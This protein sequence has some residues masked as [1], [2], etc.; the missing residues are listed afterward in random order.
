[1]EDESKPPHK[2]HLVPPRIEEAAE[3]AREALNVAHRELVRDLIRIFRMEGREDEF[4]QQVDAALRYF[5][6][7]RDHAISQWF[8]KWS[9]EEAGRVEPKGD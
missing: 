6:I 1:M 2:L 9:E 8:R 7:T 4:R 3:W 5:L